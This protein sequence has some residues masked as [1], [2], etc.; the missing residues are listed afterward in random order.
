MTRAQKS[1]EEVQQNAEKT[2]VFLR[3]RRLI[4][5][6]DVERRGGAREDNDNFQAFRTLVN[7][8]SPVNDEKSSIFF[9][10]TIIFRPREGFQ[11]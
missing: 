3:R 8:F 9:F 1:E 5:D 11:N 7:G 2:R 4:A 10:L 6:F